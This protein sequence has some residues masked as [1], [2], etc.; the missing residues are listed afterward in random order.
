ML[1]ASSSKHNTDSNKKDYREQ[2]DKEQTV[3]VLH[4]HH[5][6]DCKYAINITP[7]GEIGKNTRITCA[8]VLDGFIVKT[9]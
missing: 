5:P 8:K 3:N 6:F 7:D 4:C 2:C 1:Y 9:E